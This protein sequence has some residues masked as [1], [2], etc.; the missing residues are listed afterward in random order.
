[1]ETRSRTLDILIIGA[2][3]VG[4]AMGYHLKTTPFR[5]QLVERHKRIGDSRRKR[6]DS[7]VLATGPLSNPLFRSSLRSSQQTFCN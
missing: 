4:L 1:M 7:V 5:F 3:Q 2:G 6:Y